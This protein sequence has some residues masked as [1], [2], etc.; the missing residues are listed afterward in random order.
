M[1]IAIYSG[2]FLPQINGVVSYVVDTA[3][4]LVK[5]GHTVSVFVPKPK[6]NT[7]IN[8]SSYPFTLYFLPS[9]PGLIHPDIRVTRPSML[10]LTRTMRELSIDIVHLNDPSPLCMEG[11]MTAKFMKIPVIVTFHT[12]FFD[13]DILKTIR[14]SS[15]FKALKGPLVRL[16]TYFHNFADT[17]ICPSV[18]AQKELLASGLTSPTIV[19]HNGIDVSRIHRLTSKEKIRL[20]QRYHIAP[21]APTG[22]FVGR[23]AADKRVDVLLRVWV[24][25]IQVFPNALLVIVGTGPQ[26]K[27]LRR[28]AGKLSLAHHVL[29][30]GGVRRED[31]MKKSLYSLGDIYVSASRIE[32]QSM[33]M[34]EAMA[35]GLPIIAV[36]M[37]GVSELVDQTN[38]VLTATGVGPLAG[39]IVSV[40]GDKGTAEHLRS[41]SFKK[42]LQYDVRETVRELEKLYMSMV[43]MGEV[44]QHT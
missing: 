28:L 24:R 25:V 42:A 29:F 22:I 2:T 38:G 1:N 12:F 43:A 9:L 17:V 18:S 41:A 13:P 19:I 10:R 31:I 32:N 23:L 30:T 44:L 35:H 39:G 20:R 34:I 11:M 26:E 40:L 21:D 5:R 14:F 33:S 36:N 8:Q 4:A 37:R 27:E 15:V 7:K 3:T 16:N 6:R